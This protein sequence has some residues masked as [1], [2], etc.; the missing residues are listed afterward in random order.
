M[1]VSDVHVSGRYKGKMEIYPARSLTPHFFKIKIE[2]VASEVMTDNHH[3]EKG[4]RRQD[5]RR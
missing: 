5:Q 1:T 4:K 3:P 2:L